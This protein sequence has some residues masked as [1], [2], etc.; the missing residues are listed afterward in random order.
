M[1]QHASVE[2]RGL[3][4]V[5]V[6]GGDYDSRLLAPVIDAA[7][8]RPGGNTSRIVILLA[9]AASGP[10]TVA[11]ATVSISK[12]EIFARAD[13]VHHLRRHWGFDS[14]ESEQ[15]YSL[16]ELTGVTN[17]PARVYEYVRAHCGISTAR[18]A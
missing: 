6:V 11:G 15:V 8:E 18:I 7:L 1:R 13:V 10:D 3:V 2:A 5:L 4:T 17:Q 14:A 9:S 16:M 12:G